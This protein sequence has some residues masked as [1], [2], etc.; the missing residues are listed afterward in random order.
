MDQ[1]LKH[2]VTIPPLVPTSTVGPIPTVVPGTEPIFYHIHD[3]GKRTLW[4]VTVLMGISSLCFYTLGARVVVQ[5]RLFHVLTSLTTTISFLAYLSMATGD[6]HNWKHMHVKESHDHVPDTFQ[7]IF[8]QVFWARYVNW[9]LTNPLIIVN[10]SLLA[11]LNGASILVA[12]SADLIMFVSGLAATYARHERRWVWYTISCIGYLTVLYQVAF[13]GRRAVSNRSQQSVRFFG[14]IAG[15]TLLV[16][17]LY[18]II[19]AASP[20]AHK[21]NLDAEV[22]A[23]AVH[24]ILTQGIF[25]Y[26]LLLTHDN[27][28]ST[29]LYIDGFWASGLTGEG[30]IRVGDSE[31]A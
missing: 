3:T 9:I 15:M 18:P 31:G 12:V 22:V 27:Q 30:A 8:R 5:K 25:G 1:I 29:T 23:W 7:D 11:G 10:L 26:W 19:L 6:G 17:A 20:L 4:V 16:N 21:I 2:T 13:N 14:S 28:E 24:D